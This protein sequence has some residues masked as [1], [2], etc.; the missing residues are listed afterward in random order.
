MIASP[1]PHLHCFG[2]VT[3]MPINGSSGPDAGFASARGKAHTA[4]CL[5]RYSP[6]SEPSGRKAKTVPS[7]AQTLRRRLRRRLFGNRKGSVMPSP[8]RV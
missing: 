8:F 4:S 5:V 6:N 1:L 2:K 7:R 3:A